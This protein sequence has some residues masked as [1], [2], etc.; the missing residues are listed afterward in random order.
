[1]I[2]KQCPRCKKLHSIKERCPNGCFDYIK[3]ESDKYYDKYLRKNKEI[4]NNKLWEIVR[5][6]C[7][8]LSDNI[9]LYSLY[10]YNLIVPASLVHH[11]IEVED[12]KEKKFVY[13]VDNLIALSDKAHR[14]VHARYK[15]E[16][17]S[18]VQEELRKYKRLY[19]EGRGG[20]KKI[21]RNG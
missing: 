6:R 2:L 4:Y 13:D 21:L 1:M 5:Q 16:D 11:I 7:L 8:N 14:E 18:Q 20:M 15:K 10:K 9:C 12:D 3:K 17:I 19:Q